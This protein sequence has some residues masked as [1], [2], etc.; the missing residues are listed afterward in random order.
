M[1]NGWR[2]AGIQTNTSGP[3]IQLFSSELVDGSGTALNWP[4][5]VP[6]ERETLGDVG[7]LT[8]TAPQAANT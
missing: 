4:V 5:Y 8:Q 3:P 1:A 7:A 6:G 2:V